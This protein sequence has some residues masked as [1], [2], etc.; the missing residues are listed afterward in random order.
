MYNHSSI[1]AAV[2]LLDEYVLGL[3][4]GS[5]F[6]SEKSGSSNS[7]KEETMITFKEWLDDL[8]GSDVDP[9]DLD[10]ASYEELEN[11]YK[12]VMK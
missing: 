11:I 8:F 1:T 10:D 7:E 6:W 5:R 2:N 4:I 12:E 9:M 3:P